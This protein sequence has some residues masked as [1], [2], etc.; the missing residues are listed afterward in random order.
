MKMKLFWSKKA[1]AEMLKIARYIRKNFG[2]IAWQN[3]MDEVAQTSSCL[4]RM[5]NIGK[6]E[7]YLEDLPDIYRS[8]VVTK[9]KIVYHLETYGA[10]VESHKILPASKRQYIKAV[11]VKPR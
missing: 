10:K 8:I 11:G 6:V 7:P 9:N 5:P 4:E 1:R 3:F 2:E